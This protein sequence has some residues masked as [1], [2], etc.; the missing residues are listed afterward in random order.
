MAPSSAATSVLPFT[1]LGGQ[2]QSTTCP[3]WCDLVMVPGII[4]KAEA[5][6]RHTS[7]DKQAMHRQG[8]VSPRLLNV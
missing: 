5:G 8:Q 1:A 3:K 7:V 6:W 2:Q 4:T